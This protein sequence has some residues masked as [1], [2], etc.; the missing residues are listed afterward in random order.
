MT[1]DNKWF[2]ELTKQLLNRR[3]I[4]TGGVLKDMFSEREKNNDDLL[5][6]EN[7]TKPED[8]EELQN[9]LRFGWSKTDRRYKK[10]NR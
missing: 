6:D 4:G 10:V 7:N 1:T 5:Y 2:I 8:D 9:L 3:F